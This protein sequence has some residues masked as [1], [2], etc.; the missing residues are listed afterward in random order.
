MPAS[1]PAPVQIHTDVAAGKSCGRGTSDGSGHVAVAFVEAGQLSVTWQVFGADG[2]LEQRMTVFRDLVPQPEG[3]QGA[4]PSAQSGPVTVD[5]LTFFGDGSP[6]RSETPMPGFVTFASN[7]TFAGDPLGGSVLAL[8]GFPSPPPDGPCPGEARRY[9]ATGAPRGGAGEVG[10]NLWAAGVSNQGEALVISG[11]A[12]QPP[13]QWLTP[14]G[15]PAAPASVDGGAGRVF[16]S[17]RVTLVPLLDG[18]LVVHN[19]NDGTWKRR[20]PHLAAGG[21]AAPAWLAPRSGE[22]L[23]FTRGNRGYAI[24][25]GPGT[26]SADC[27]QV[28]ELVAQSGRSCVRLTFREDAK[29][30][31]NGFID[32]GWDG[33]VVQQSG[34]DP[35]SYRWWP[36]LLAGP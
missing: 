15:T 10:C 9:D 34:K 5:V 31:T 32:Q 13:L 20:Y 6:R 29:D 12:L 26:P 23:R 7:F 19:E 30:C 11:S 24:F 2:S 3:W 25:P 28:A 36:E 14:D 8:T 16:T 4:L 22:T 35:C 33:T 1:V 18:S 21:E 17:G 27:T